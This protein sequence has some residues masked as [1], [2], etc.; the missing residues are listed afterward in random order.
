MTKSM[1][2]ADYQIQVSSNYYRLVLLKAFI[3]TKL[4]PP[5]FIGFTGS[6]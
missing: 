6:S 4:E 1:W 5:D 2:T 3:L